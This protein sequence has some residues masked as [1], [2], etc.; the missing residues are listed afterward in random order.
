MRRYKMLARVLLVFFVVDFALAAPAVIQKPRVRVS[1][2]DAVKDEMATSLLR[3]D[4]SGKWSTGHWREQESRQHNQRPRDD[5]NGSPPP[6]PV[7]LNEPPGLPVDQ[8]PG[9][10]SALAS[11]SRSLTD[12]PDPLNTPWPHGNVDSNTSPY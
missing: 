8:P 6:N 11:S 9:P 2:V 4:S 3:R 7:L 1:R 10:A 5:S 12:E